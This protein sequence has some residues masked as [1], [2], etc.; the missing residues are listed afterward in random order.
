MKRSLIVLALVVAGISTS[1][2][3][4]STSWAAEPAV[5]AATATEAA[6]VSNEQMVTWYEMGRLGK[7]IWLFDSRPAG[8]YIAGHIPGAINLPLDVLKKDPAAVISKY[9]IPKNSTVVF[10]CA[11]RECT[12]SV[13]SADIFRKAG[14]TTAMV[15]R[16]GVPGWNQKLQPLLATEAFIKKGNVILIDTMPGQGTI[17]ANGVQTLQMSLK[18]LGAE[19]GKSLLADLSRNA[20]LVVVGRGDAEAVNAA[21]EELRDQDFRRLAYFPVSAWAAPLA[22]APSLVKASWTPVYAPGQ[23]STKEFERAVAA[24]EYILDIR[25]PSDFARGH[26]RNAINLP[27]EDF[28]KLSD[29]IPKDRTVFIHCASGAKSQKAFDILG[30]KGYTNLKY[31]DAEVACKGEVCTIKE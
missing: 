20:P 6:E 16:N 25:P 31:L 28:E 18:E 14:Y 10:Y 2:A 7:D 19:K 8:K 24:A 21:L 1:T 5:A 27:I 13:D 30:R 23:I 26:F 22:A 4:T 3:L 12:L 11:G 17:I 9:A 15:Y 29:R